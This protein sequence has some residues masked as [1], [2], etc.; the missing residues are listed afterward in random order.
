MVKISKDNEEDCAVF[1]FR[2]PSCYGYIFTNGKKCLL[3]SNE[4]FPTNA[5]DF[6][7]INYKKKRLNGLNDL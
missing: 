4:C 6:K 3:L 7:A 1:C 5:T 2:T